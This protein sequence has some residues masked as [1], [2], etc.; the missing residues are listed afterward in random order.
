MAARPLAR[1]QQNL[2]AGAER[3][4][5]TWLC[6]RLPAWVTPDRLTAFGMAGAVATFIG[7]AASALGT[8]W[9]WLAVAGYVAQWFGDSLDGSLARYRHI[10][11]PSYGYFLDHSCDGLATLLILGGIGASPFVRLDIALLA[12]IGYLL[13]S[14]H[15]YLAARV[16][17]ELKLSYLAAG[18]TELR[19]FLIGLTI[20]MMMVRPDTNPS[21]MGVLDWIVG[22]IGLV[23]IGLFVVQTLVTARRLSSVDQPKQPD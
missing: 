15:G 18:P 2:L 4:L 14:V 5:L 17:G 7:Y 12:T 19:L 11:R 21:D 3:R 1:I 10:E 16:I 8:A 23:L 22:G 9:L 20:A 6:A 13:L